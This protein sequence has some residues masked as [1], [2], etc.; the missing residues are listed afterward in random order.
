MRQIYILDTYT[1]CKEIVRYMRETN[2]PVIN[3]FPEHSIVKW[4]L[5]LAIERIT[6]LIC[7]DEDYPERDTGCYCATHALDPLLG[8]HLPFKFLSHV[9][10]V[11]EIKTFEIVL[12]PTYH[13]YLIL[14][15]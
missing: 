5:L 9:I 4:W 1:P 12:Y 14:G 15:N 10:S 6:N 8:Y 11:G 13:G 2:N 3:W 7:V